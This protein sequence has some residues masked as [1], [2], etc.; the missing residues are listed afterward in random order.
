MIWTT[1]TSFD[2]LKQFCKTH[3]YTL[4][5]IAHFKEDYVVVHVM[6]DLKGVDVK[7]QTESIEESAAQVHYILGLP[8]SSP[9]P[10]QKEDFDDFL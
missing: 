6:D 7:I 3:K 9:M 8:E 1:M 10:E 5:V 2:Q 4:Y